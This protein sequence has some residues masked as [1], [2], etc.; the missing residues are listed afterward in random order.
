MLLPALL[1]PLLWAGSLQEEPSYWL[2]AQRLVTVQENLCV[3][4]SC[5]FSYPRGRWQNSTPTYGCWYRQNRNLFD[6]T[7]DELVAT[8]DPGRKAKMRSQP[9]FQLL[10]DPMAY[11]CSLQIS[12]AQQE[13]SGSYYFR[14]ERGEIKYNYRKWMVTVIVTELTQTPDI[15]ILEPLVSGHLSH[16]LCSMPGVCSGGMNLTFFWNGAALRPPGSGSGAHNSSEIMLTPRPQD[17]GSLLT[18]RVT[19]PEAGVTKERTV[20]LSVFYPP[21]DL[22]VM[23]TQA[24]S[25]ALDTQGN[26]SYLEVHKDQ[27]VQLLCAADSW[28]P[29]TLTWELGGRVVS[30]S[31]PS[32]PRPLRL[33]LPRVKPEDAG[34]YT[35]RAES[36]LGSKHHT[37]DLSVQYPPE[38][39]RVTVTQANSTVLEILGNGTSL[40][41]LEGQSLRLVCITHSKPPATLNWILGTQALNPSWLTAPGVLEL[42]RVQLEHEGEVTCHAE[43]PLGSRSVSL[44]LS[45]H[46]SPQLLGPTCSWEAAGLHCSCSSRARPAPSLCWWLGQGLL[47]GNGSN[48]SFTVTSSASGP[49][50]NSSLSLPAGLSSSLRLSCEVQN[51][52]GVHSTAVLRLRGGNSS[53]TLSAKVEVV[54]GAALCFLST[55]THSKVDARRVAS[56][57]DTPRALCPVC[58]D[59]GPGRHT[60]D[61]RVGFGSCAPAAQPPRSSQSHLSAFS[62]LI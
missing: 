11:N 14:V 45:V 30:Q 56:Q 35:C 38:E 48:V 9:R 26:G 49:W 15:R 43:N 53:P 52:H 10:G 6:Y 54:K 20:Q 8:N 57:K 46:Y 24:N 42:P 41:V 47:E 25:T 19:L 39:L 33:E 1:V 16:L 34:R 3:L 32:G 60:R 51:V 61:A 40:P 58:R 13:D 37:L 4:V 2:Q 59:A 5:S 17:H 44:R 23:V 27:L 12:G 50:V 36:S 18:C 31:P 22:K 62:S 21:E 7:P 55:K 28:P 29:A